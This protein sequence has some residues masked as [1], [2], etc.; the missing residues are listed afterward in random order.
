MAEGFAAA[1][2]GASQ[3]GRRRENPIDAALRIALYFYY[4]SFIVRLEMPFILPENHAPAYG[5][6]T[7]RYTPS[8]SPSDVTVRDPQRGRTLGVLR[9]AG[10]APRRF[11]LAPLMPLP[12]ALAPL[13]AGPTGFCDPYDRIPAV[14]LLCGADASEVRTALPASL[15][16]APG[17]LLTSLPR[18][19]AVVAGGCDEVA[20]R[21]DGSCMARVTVRRGGT[22]SSELFQ[23]VA[24]GGVALFRIA[25]PADAEAVLTEFTVEGASVPA[26]VSHTVAGAWERGVGV[27]WLNELGG[28]DRIG[29]PRIEEA[30][31]L[32]TPD[33]PCERLM[34]RSAFEPE[35]TLRALAGILTARAVWVDRSGRWRRVEVATDEACVRRGERPGALTLEVRPWEGTGLC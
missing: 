30:T 23:G 27:A 7:V 28:I 2:L 16:S 18:S 17:D 6:Y 4:P 31:L 22:V 15:P 10:T 35:A 34:L 12:E 13:E 25:A 24:A 19:R 14:Q 26:S 11:D 32:R 33:G 3:E 20:V 5:A 21:C 29:F 8:V 1:P 9:F